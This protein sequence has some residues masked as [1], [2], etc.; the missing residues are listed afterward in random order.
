MLLTIRPSEYDIFIG[1]DVDRY[2]VKLPL[3]VTQDHLVGAPT[4]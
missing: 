2:P 1:I 4:R 3:S